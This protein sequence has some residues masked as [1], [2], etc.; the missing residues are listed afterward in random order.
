MQ[1]HVTRREMIRSSALAG[2]G[3]WLSGH[4]RASL[5][6]PGPNEKLNI[7]V[8]GCGGRGASNLSSVKSEN[9]VALCDVD[10]RRAAASFARYPRAKKY[11]DFRKMFDQMENQIDAV[12]V[13]APNHIHAPASVMAMRMGKHCYCEKPLTHSVY[14]ARLMAKLASEKKLATQM[15]TQIHAS[16]NYRRIVEWIKSG[17]IGPVSECHIRLAGGGAASD[18]PKQTPPVPSGLH[19]DLWLGPAP[20]R[21]YHPCYVPHDWHYWWDF[22]GGAFGNMGCH[23]LD[24]A[25]WALDLRHPTTIETEGSPVHLESTPQQ[26]TARYEF[27]A[28]GQLPPVALTWD[29]GRKRPPFWEKHK[30]PDWAWGVFVGS[31]G[32][33]L[34]SYNKRMLWPESQFAEFE[35]PEPVIPASIGHHKEWITACKTGSPT[36]CNFDYSGALAETVLLGNVACRAGKKLRWDAVNMTSTNCPEADQYLS[37]EY[38]NGWSL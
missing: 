13:A 6:S 10:E 28:R 25:F 37:R 20:H 30:I 11:H 9:I 38:R 15:G 1:R 31:K 14:E 23:Y 17:A 21:P 24:L 36:L 35:D 12:V 29:H 32:M 8:I 19:W 26:F 18:R 22:G 2:V 4:A 7:A 5:G 3:A 16:D 34:A 33:V 27:A